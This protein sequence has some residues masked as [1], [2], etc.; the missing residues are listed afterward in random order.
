MREANEGHSRRLLSQ[1][2]PRR[3][4]IRRSCVA[5]STDELSDWPIT[6]HSLIPY[7]TISYRLNIRLPH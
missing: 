7:R 2:A 1:R 4:G 5:S 6:E 3:R